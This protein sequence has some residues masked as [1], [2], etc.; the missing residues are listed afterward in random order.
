MNYLPAILESNNRVI[1]IFGSEVWIK[2]RFE[3]FQERYPDYCQ[4]DTSSYKAFVNKFR[5]IIEKIKS[6]GEKISFIHIFYRLLTNLEQ[7][8]KAE[9]SLTD[10]QGRLKDPKYKK[11]LSKLPI[12]TTRIVGKPSCIL[13]V[14]SQL[15]FKMSPMKLWVIWIAILSWDSM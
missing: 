15:F 14:K 10:C 6:F 13:T 1:K 3:K 2:K 11:A 4:N 5:K 8:K 12:Q 7:L 9:H